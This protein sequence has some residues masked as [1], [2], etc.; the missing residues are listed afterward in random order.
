MKKKGLKSM[1]CSK[2][3][4]KIAAIALNHKFQK[5]HWSAGD[6]RSAV[7]L[8]GFVRIC[9]SLHPF[10]MHEGECLVEEGT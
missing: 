4:K 1:V 8:A 6:L 7:D 9:F 3:I 2:T 5:K 10:F